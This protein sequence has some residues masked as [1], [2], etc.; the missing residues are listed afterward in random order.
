MEVLKQSVIDAKGT[1]NKFE[2][3]IDQAKPKLEGPHMIMLLQADGDELEY[4]IQAL[5]NLPFCYSI[6]RWHGNFAQFVYE[7][8]RTPLIGTPIN[9]KKLQNE[10]D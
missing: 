2:W 5:H 1:V 7:N 9:L 10:Q 6:C 3:Y 4:I 8:I